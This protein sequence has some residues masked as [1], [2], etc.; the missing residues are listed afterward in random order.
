MNEVIAIFACVCT[1]SACTQEL[2]AALD[3]PV[4]SAALAT[5]TAGGDLFELPRE[6]APGSLEVTLGLQ[7]SYMVPFTIDV[8]EFHGEM[9]AYLC[10]LVADDGM[11][12]VADFP[13]RFDDEGHLATHMPI[14]EVEMGQPFGDGTFSC[15]VECL[16]TGQEVSTPEYRIHLTLGSES[17]P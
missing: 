8:P 4:L 15:L 10:N 7:G 17:E 2:S 16:S 1:L 9:S 14:P 5:R 11:R 3:E 13:G 6:G 12:F